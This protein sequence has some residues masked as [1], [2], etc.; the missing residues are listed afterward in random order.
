MSPGHSF[1]GLAQ[2]V[3]AAFARWDVSHLHDFEL[4]DGRTIGIP[5]IDYPDGMARRECPEGRQRS[6]RNS[7]RKNP[8]SWILMRSGRSWGLDQADRFQG[9]VPNPPL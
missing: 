8:A 7:I 1:G 6:S 4:V 9:V 2:A 3:N 5:D